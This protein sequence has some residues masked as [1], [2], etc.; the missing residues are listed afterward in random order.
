MEVKKSTFIFS[1]ASKSM[2]ERETEWKKE[3]LDLEEHFKAMLKD[4]K[5]RADVS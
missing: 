5:G 3:Q 4:V 1:K 2:K